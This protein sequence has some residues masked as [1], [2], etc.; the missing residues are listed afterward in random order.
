[1][2][3]DFVGSK[4]RWNSCC[5]GGR[6][7]D[8]REAIRPILDLYRATRAQTLAVVEGLSQAQMDYVP[9]PGKWSPGEVLDH[10]LLGERLNL[11]YIHEIIEMKKAGKRPVLKLSLTDVDVSIAYLPKSLLQFF[12]VPLTVMNM[13]LPGS[14]RDL[15]TRYSLIPAQNAEVTTPRHG[16]CAAEL[17]NDLICSLQETEALFD[18]HSDLDYGETVIQHPLLGSNSIPELIRFLAL[19]EQRHQSQIEEIL[20]DARFPMVDARQV[21]V[22]R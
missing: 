11:C 21:E 13:F 15:M 7:A 18:A 8:S 16:R 5:D 12:E 19:H 22:E 20:S 3:P 6:P 10:L 4:E 14:I 17:R 9:A 1:M 2:S